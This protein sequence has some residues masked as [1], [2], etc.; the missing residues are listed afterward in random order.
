MTDSERVEG[1]ESQEEIDKERRDVGPLP[2]VDLSVKHPLQVSY[3]F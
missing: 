3:A 2:S 1:A